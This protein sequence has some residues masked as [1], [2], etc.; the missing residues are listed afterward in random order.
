VSVQANRPH[1]TLDAPDPVLAQGR[2]GSRKS[3]PPPDWA[4]ELAQTW[5]EYSAATKTPTW[6]KATALGL[7]LLAAIGLVFDTRA[8]LIFALTSLL[9]VFLA[10]ACL[11]FFAW[12]RLWRGTRESA[13]ASAVEPAG[14]PLPVYSILIPLY[15]ESEVVPN[16]LAALS[17][18]NYPKD[19]LDILF[20][21]EAD[22]A[23][24]QDALLQHVTGYHMRVLTVPAGLP[25]TKPRALMYALHFS[26]GDYVVVYDAEDEPDPQ[27]LR[28]ALAMFEQPGRRLG[29]V[30]AQL[31]IYNP[32]ESWLTKQFTLEYTAL[33]DAILPALGA[34][35]L[36]VP[37]G[38]TS[39]HF[40]RA[41]LDSIGGW[42]P[43]NVTEDAD[44]GVRLARLGWQVSILP[45]TTW[46]E[47][48]NK[49]GAWFG[50]RVRWLK[51]WMQTYLVHN[52]QPLKLYADLGAVRFA[53]FQLLMGG[54]ILSALVHPLFCAAVIY[55]SI[56]N[57]HSLWAMP[58][59]KFDQFFWFAGILN[60]LLAYVTAAGLAAVAIAKRG[61][62]ALAWQALLLPV[63]WLLISVAA[64]RALAQLIT[65]PY[66][67]QKTTHRARKTQIT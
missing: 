31:N 65:A 61:R 17:R 55:D 51:G 54:L 47:A 12:A 21:I 60:M 41:V 58:S 11:R 18:L 8:T 57:G 4:N 48:P 38:G 63:Y 66:W 6:Q 13:H 30:Q 1:D 34:L 15:D 37:L 9:P 67:W 59:T 42:D 16:L 44:L 28:L 3:G 45:S 20:A 7:A 19:K 43:Y 35:R 2:S 25:R 33:F 52:R 40:P 56:W 36:P 5:P 24:T 10:V 50:Q 32:N 46:E 23:V 26:H 64:Y 62:S 39:N 14:A 49:F 27:Q 29:C 22:D 53:G